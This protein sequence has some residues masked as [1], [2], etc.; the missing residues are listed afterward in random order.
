LLESSRYI[1]TA[2]YPEC[3]IADISQRFLSEVHAWNLL[4]HGDVDAIPL[5]GVYSADAHPFGLVYEYMDGLTS[6]IT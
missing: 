3:Y 2:V 6:S 5:A 4:H 1:A